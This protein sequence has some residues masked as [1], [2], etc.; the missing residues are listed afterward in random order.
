MTAGACT[1]KQ[2]GHS[3]RILWLSD[4]TNAN[5]GAMK[6]EEPNECLN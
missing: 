2:V 5:N 1:E 6:K 3:Q 4:L